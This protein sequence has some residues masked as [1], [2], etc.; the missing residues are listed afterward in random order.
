MTK[1]IITNLVAQFTRKNT[2]YGGSAHETFLNFGSAS[3]AI[4][5]HDKLNRYE[6]LISNPDIPHG[7]EAIEDTLGDAVT[8]TAMFVADLKLEMMGGS[9]CHFNETTDVLYLLGACTPE[10]IKDMSVRFGT[11][12]MFGRTLP[13]TIISM[14]N[15]NSTPAEYVMLAAYL[16][17][18]LNERMKKHE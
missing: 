18:L 15:S 1:E 16:L 11:E 2:A 9:E 7:D 3:Y 14:W 10:E 8:Y 12:M 4:R 6:Q 5:I 13:E 17:N